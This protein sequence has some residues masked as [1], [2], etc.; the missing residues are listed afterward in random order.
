M[1]NKYTIC[2]YGAASQDIDPVYLKNVEKLGKLIA[3]K[4]HKL[5]YGGGA[6][7]LMGAC[8]RGVSEAGG[9]VIGVVPTFINK[10]EPIYE[11]CTQLIK[12]E[13]MAQRKSVMEDNA[14]AFVIV[15]GGIGTFDE[16]FQILTLRELGRQTEPIILFDIKYYYDDLIAFMEKCTRKGFIKPMVADLFAVCRTP[17]EVIDAVEKLIGTDKKASEYR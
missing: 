5:I 15:P 3:Q 13:T 2:M 9:Q 11:G 1:S 4:N 14:D 16:F 6:G 7:G 17:E 12:T 8:A 10:M